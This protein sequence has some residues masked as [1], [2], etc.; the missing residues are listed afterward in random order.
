MIW[1]ILV[2]I[3]VGGLAGWVASMI[4]KTDAQQGALA[5]IVIGIIGGVIGGVILRALGGD[6]FTGLNIWSFVVAL[7]GSIVLLLILGAVR[8]RR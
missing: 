2:W 1:N 8:G 3:I 5:N 4:M 7:V 6:G